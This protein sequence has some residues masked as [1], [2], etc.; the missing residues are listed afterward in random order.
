MVSLNFKLQVLR[1]TSIAATKA[2]MI[3]E[4]IQTALQK[5]ADAKLAVTKKRIISG[6]AMTSEIITDTATT[7]SDKTAE[8]CDLLIA[9]QRAVKTVM[10]SHSDSESDGSE[11][12][13]DKERVCLLDSG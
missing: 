5:D 9:K 7:V 3:T 6:P 4:L 12:N 11:M 8:P 10:L 1:C 2:A 13:V